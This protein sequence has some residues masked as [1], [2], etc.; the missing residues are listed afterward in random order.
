MPWWMGLLLI[1]TALPGLVAPALAA[2]IPE[3]NI[4]LRE[5]VRFF[6][7]YSLASLA[8]AWYCYCHGRATIAWILWVLSL[9]S[10]LCLWGLLRLFH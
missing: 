1:V 3:S 5:I 9:L 2:F 6:P 8:L 7:C 4:E 10:D